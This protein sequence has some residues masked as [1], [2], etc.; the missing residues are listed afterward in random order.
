LPIHEGIDLVVERDD[1][2]SGAGVEAPGN[3]SHGIARAPGSR[4]FAPDLGSNEQALEALSEGVVQAGYKPGKDVVLALDVAASE[5]YSRGKYKL[6]AE[7]KPTKSGNPANNSHSNLRVFCI[8]CHSR[9]PY[10]SQMLRNSSYRAKIEMIY[11]LRQSQGIG[12]L[13]TTFQDS[14]TNG[15]PPE[16][17]VSMWAHSLVWSDVGAVPLSRLCASTVPNEAMARRGPDGRMVPVPD[18]STY[19]L[20]DRRS[21]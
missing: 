12:N 19:M 14:P 21:C 2:G 17:M 20:A 3:L 6:A 15:P 18:R 8:E 1:L 10:H 4:R 7:K 9:Q 16:L 13:G 11:E 5:L